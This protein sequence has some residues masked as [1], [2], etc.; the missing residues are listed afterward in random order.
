[1]PARVHAWDAPVRLFHWALAALVVFS[2][3]TGK[4]GGG[5]MEWHLRSGYSILTLLLFRVAWGF[6]GGTTARFT[7]FVR[8]P[9]AALEHV[10]AIVGRRLAAHAGHNPLGGWMV[11]AMLAALL[12][13]AGSGLFADDEISTQGPLS[14]KASSAL[15][16]RMSWLHEY[17][18]WVIVALVVLHVIAIA[19]Y[20][21]GLKVNLVGPMVHGTALV[22]AN[23]PAAKPGSNVLAAVI[24]AAA[25]AF[26]YWLVAI[27]PKSP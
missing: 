19:V 21:W 5:W 12:T 27:Y 7:G 9:R 24:L 18:Q 4:L 16:G 20:Q 26:V 22:D 3:V 11:L 14:I 17:N 1:M 6:A 23:H 13:Q 10:R 2:F 15:V 25:A 8:G